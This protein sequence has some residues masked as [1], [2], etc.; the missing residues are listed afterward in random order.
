LLKKIGEAVI[1]PIA[2]P[3]LM[4]HLRNVK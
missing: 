3:E 1:H 2:V 4:N